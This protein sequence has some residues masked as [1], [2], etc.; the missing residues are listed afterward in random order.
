MTTTTIQ[1]GVYDTVLKK[2]AQSATDC[3][4]C[5]KEADEQVVADALRELANQYREKTRPPLGVLE[6]STLRGLLDAY[7][8]IFDEELDT[9]VFLYSE[10]RPVTVA[11]GVI[12]A[13]GFGDLDVGYSIEENLDQ[14]PENIIAMIA[15]AINKFNSSGVADAD[16]YDG[17]SN[18]EFIEEHLEAYAALNTAYSLAQE[19]HFDEE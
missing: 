2:L 4:R 13:G 12:F 11:D 5:H 19:C 15:N 18:I 16:H 8:R 3:S 17:P 6:Q 7:E 1:S 10:N 9:D 14:I